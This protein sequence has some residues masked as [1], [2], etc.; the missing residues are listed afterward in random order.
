MGSTARGL[1]WQ[2][3]LGLANAGSPGLVS[4]YHGLTLG[5]SWELLPSYPSKPEVCPNSPIS[6]F[7]EFW[8]PLAHPMQHIKGLVVSVS[9][10]SAQLPPTTNSQ[11]TIKCSPVKQGQS[12][13]L[14]LLGGTQNYMTTYFITSHNL[15]FSTWGCSGSWLVEILPSSQLTHNLQMTRH[16]M[17]VL[18]VGESGHPKLSHAPTEQEH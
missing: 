3:H 11:L 9:I 15:P 10:T 16:K 12:P 14:S 18:R 1:L 6:T 7:S 2:G 4:G 5:H 17:L 8:S 13:C